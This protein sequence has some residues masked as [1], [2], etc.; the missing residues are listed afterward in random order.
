M[1]SSG[2]GVAVVVVR[3]KREVGAGVGCSSR[4]NTTWSRIFWVFVKYTRHSLCP[5]PSCAGKIRSSSEL[6]G[7]DGEG[8]GG[9][10]CGGGGG[11]DGGVVAAAEETVAEAMIDY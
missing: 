10:D 3:R 4:V 7:G 11:G 9:K 5:G 1:L 6:W 8:I 2:S